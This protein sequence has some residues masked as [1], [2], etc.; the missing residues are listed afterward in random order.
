VP[1]IKGISLARNL[2]GALPRLP[3]P[4]DRVCDRSRLKS[5]ASGITRCRHWSSFL[6]NYPGANQRA[7][8]EKERERERESAMPTRS[9]ITLDPRGLLGVERYD[10]GA[11]NEP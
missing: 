11:K 9:D 8:L 7:S 10:R 6:V 2:A 4:E 5:G 3:A 1:E